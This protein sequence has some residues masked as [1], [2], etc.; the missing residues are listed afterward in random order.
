M[1]ESSHGSE[2]SD[3]V[4]VH[5][6]AGGVT[7]LRP[8]RRLD[9]TPLDDCSHR[10]QRE[11]PPAMVWHDDL[12]S[13]SN[14]AP[15]LVAARGTSKNETVPAE[16]PDHLIRREARSPAITQPSPQP[17]SPWG[18]VRCRRVKGRVGL[19]LRCCALPLLPYRRRTH[20]RATRG[21]RRSNSPLPGRTPRPRGT[22]SLQYSAPRP[23]GE[24]RG[25]RR[26]RSPRP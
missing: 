22:S 1:G 3:G 6:R 2:V 15:L 24:F 16:N 26:L 10:A 9:S 12:F 17:A 20:I 19:P 4:V 7:L 21:T 13:R 23:C 5:P 11:N 25:G 8:A 14:V 18:I